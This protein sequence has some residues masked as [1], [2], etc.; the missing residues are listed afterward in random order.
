MQE[1]RLNLLIQRLINQFLSFL[2]NPW[3]QLSLIIICLLLGFFLASAITT[4]AG[5]SA[6]WDTT[7]ALFFLIF[8]EVSNNIIYRRSKNQEKSPWLDLFNALKIGFVYGLYLEALK[9][10]S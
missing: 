3:R 1:T 7:L 8:T 9:L 2:G 6:R 4:S 10:G 5:Q